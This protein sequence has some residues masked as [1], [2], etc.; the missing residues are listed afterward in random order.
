L[1]KKDGKL[2]LGMFETKPSRVNNPQRVMFAKSK[3][4][5]L[6]HLKE[7]NCQDVDQY[8]IGDVV[9]ADLFKDQAFVDVTAKTKG[10]GFTGVIKRH[11]FKLNDKTHG[12]SLVWRSHGS[13]GNR[14]D[15]G[16]VFKNKKMAGHYGNETCSIQNLSVIG[17]DLEKK[18]L[19]VCGAV[20]GP[21]GGLVY[22]KRAVK[23]NGGLK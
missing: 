14:Q 17:V 8:A 12:A 6:K 2:V 9:D 16:R 18:L 15:P 3:L 23:K 13:T 11:H 10:R 5:N 20:P 19:L 1:T 4:P 7:F 22:V 21:R